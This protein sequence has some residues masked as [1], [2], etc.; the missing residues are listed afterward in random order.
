MVHSTPCLG[1]IPA[2]EAGDEEQQQEAEDSARSDHRYR[3]QGKRGHVVEGNKAE[4]DE[5]Y[6]GEP[7]DRPL[8]DILPH[9]DADDNPTA[10]ATSMP[11]VVPSHICTI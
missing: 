2:C 11:E 4:G 10:S 7:F 8:G 9:D 1:V 5:G 3:L 6:G